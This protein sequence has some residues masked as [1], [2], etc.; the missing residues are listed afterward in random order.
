M[1]TT[2]L[3][4]AYDLRAP[5]FG[6]DPADLYEAALDQ[7][8]W[9]D[10]LGFQAVSFME[11]HASSDGY[12]PSPI[13]MGAAAAAR[14]RRMQ[15][16]VIVLLPLYDPLRAAEDLAVLDN[17]SRGRLRITAI[18]GYR[19]EEYRQFGLDMRS[20]PSRMERALSVLK[21]AWT[22]EPFDF[23]GRQV[24]VLPRPTQ[25]PR[26]TLVLGGSSRA[27]AQRAARLADGFRPVVPELMHDYAQALERL[28]KPA[29]QV[30]QASGP[31]Y[32]FL[33]VTQDPDAD[34]ERIAPHA[35]HENNEYARWLQGAPNPVYF[36]AENADALRA[37]GSYQIVTPRRCLEM[38]RRDGYLAFKPLISGLDPALAW[39]SLRLFEREVLPELS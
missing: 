17:I 26:P 7:C 21:Q 31:R 10:R 5:D 30:P 8:E 4:L 13:V 33:H 15:I 14:T 6:A 28:G 16:G 36:H 9:A 24:R 38:A 1:S 27:A 19:A 2:V 35:L 18:A 32:L 34:W 29:P 22:G 23:E 25:R 3:S 39:Q 37:S 11:H 12:L 20:R